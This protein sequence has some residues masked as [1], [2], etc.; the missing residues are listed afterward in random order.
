MAGSL[1]MSFVDR[2]LVLCD[3]VSARCD[4]DDPRP[5]AAQTR[6]LEGPFEIQDNVYHHAPDAPQVQ[7]INRIIKIAN[8]Q[9]LFPLFL[10]VPSNDAPCASPT[11]ICDGCF[12]GE[13]CLGLLS[14]TRWSNQAPS[15]PG[16]CL[17]ETRLER[18]KRRAKRECFDQS[19]YRNHAVSKMLLAFSKSSHAAAMQVWMRCS[20]RTIS[21][22]GQSMRAP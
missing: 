4:D 8:E 21:V 18:F 1:V 17:L 22:A 7:V 9:L 3:P 12:T 14:V 2:I 11:L 5:R 20:P 13:K 6:T 16:R 15:P 10:A 19:V